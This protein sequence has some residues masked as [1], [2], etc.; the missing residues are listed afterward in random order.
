MKMNT[1]VFSGQSSWPGQVLL[2]LTIEATD[3][4]INYKNC[5]GGNVSKLSKW[6]LNHKDT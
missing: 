1:N 3:E 4:L 2:R 5:F 6:N